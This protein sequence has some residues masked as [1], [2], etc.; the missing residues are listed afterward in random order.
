MSKCKSILKLIWDHFDSIWNYFD[1]A[2][3]IFMVGF[4]I[5]ESNIFYSWLMLSSYLSFLKY[6]RAFKSYRI[7]IQLVHACIRSCREFI[8]VLF[9]IMVGFTNTFYTCQLDK[10]EQDDYITTS[11][12][13]FNLMIGASDTSGYDPNEWAIF[14]VAALLIMVLLMNLL[15]AIISDTFEEVMANITTSSYLQ[16]CDI[17]LE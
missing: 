15:I 8:V 12:N 3:L 16:L 1:L 13:M 5:M 10:N 4:I 6:L 7:F 17:I 11:Q 2:R 9:I 14:I